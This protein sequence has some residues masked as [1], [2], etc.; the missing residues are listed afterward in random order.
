MTL[1]R[2]SPMRELA[3]MQ[4]Q[5]DRL[6]NGVGSPRWGDRD[7]FPDGALFAP[8]DVLEAEDA[9]VLRAELP[10]MKLEDIKVHLVDNVLT[11]KGEKKCEQREEKG[12]VLHGER[13][14]GAFERSFTLGAPIQVDKIKARYTDGVL[15][16]R[17]TK[18]DD[19]KLKEIKIEQ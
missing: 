3:T 2:W 6:F 11:I 13:S 5:M 1:V 4:N 7:A 19:Q 18:S 17:L 10:G 14:Y 15:E 12:N 16:V 8:V 9:Y